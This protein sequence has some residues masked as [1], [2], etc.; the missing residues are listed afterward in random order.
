MASSAD[1]R[2]KAKQL[3]DQAQSIANAEERLGVILKAIEFEAD[4]DAVEI[5]QRTDG[6]EREKNT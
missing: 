4:A 5:E 1:L 2:A 6:G 3:Y